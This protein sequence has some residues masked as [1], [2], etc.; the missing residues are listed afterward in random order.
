M[1]TCAPPK[2]SAPI[3]QTHIQVTLFKQTTLPPFLSSLNYQHDHTTFLVHHT[4]HFSTSHRPSHIHIRHRTHRQLRYSLSCLQTDGE[5]LGYSPLPEHRQPSRALQSHVVGKQKQH[6]SER[7]TVSNC[8]D[9]AI[10]YLARL[11]CSMDY[12]SGYVN[13]EMASN[14]KGPGGAYL[15]S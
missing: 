2:V 15:L 8:G 5:R 7:C 10:L 11:R 1:R 6:A 9:G 13:S 14:R 4:R 3:P 12:R